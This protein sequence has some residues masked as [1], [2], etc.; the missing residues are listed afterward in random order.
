[1]D[2]IL[3]STQLFSIDHIKKYGKIKSIS[4]LELKSNYENSSRTRTDYFKKCLSDYLEEIK[5]ICAREGIKLYKILK[6]PKGKYYCFEWLDHWDWPIDYQILNSPMWIL[7]GKLRN[8]C[9][10]RRFEVFYQQ[11]RETLHIFPEIVNQDKDN[12][13]RMSDEDQRQLGEMKQI[14][15]PTNRSNSL[16]WLDKF[17]KTRLKD[18]GPFQD[19]MNP[20]HLLNYHAG[21]SPMLNLGLLVPEDIL[22]RI[23]K[24]HKWPSEHQ[25]SYEGFIRQ[26]FWREYMA[27]IFV[28]DR[29]KLKESPMKNIFNHHEQLSDLWYRADGKLRT[30][31]PTL[32][33]KVQQAL[34]FGYLHHIERLMFIGCFMLIKSIHPDQV[35][36]WFMHCFLDSHHWVMHG[37][38]YYMSQFAN[39]E[40]YTSK[41][42]LASGTY[43]HKMSRLTDE[44]L[45]VWD[46]YYVDWVKEKRPILEKKYMMSGH[47]KRAEL[48][49]R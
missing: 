15:F 25:S 24:S 7:P 38:V 20:D 17:I 29:I 47:L 22:S 43:L 44:E 39:G 19:Y 35:Y 8:E 10:L 45:Q 42:Y 46:H 37:N 30:G 32:D 41:L 12:R 18:F 40:T 34:Q 11:M 27:M 14:I 16:E 4:V 48:L 5:P 3:L 1:M 6:L 21:I 9:K 2:L 23:P 31:I 36:R 49:D 13:K 28:H 26:L 33:L